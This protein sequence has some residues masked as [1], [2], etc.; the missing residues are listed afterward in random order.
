[1]WF[2]FVSIT[3]CV[4]D[5]FRFT[6]AHDSIVIGNNI[7]LTLSIVASVKV[8]NVFNLLFVT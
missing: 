1:M 5:D 2:H 4:R 3:E 8:Y 6:T 7:T